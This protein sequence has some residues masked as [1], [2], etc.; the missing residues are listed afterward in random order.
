MYKIFFTFSS[1][2]SIFQILIVLSFVALMILSSS[3]WIIQ[4]TSDSCPLNTW[5][6]S[7]NSGSSVFD[8]HTIKWESQFFDWLSSPPET[9]YHFLI[10]FFLSPYVIQFFLLY[11][12]LFFFWIILIFSPKVETILESNKHNN[13]FNKCLDCISIVC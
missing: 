4:L 10:A 7:K 2:L 9:N 5:N 6:K 11:F 1:T 13:L 3:N 8:F 12:H